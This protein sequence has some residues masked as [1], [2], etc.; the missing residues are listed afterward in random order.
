MR[1]RNRLDWVAKLALVREFQ[2]AQNLAPDDPV[3]A[4]P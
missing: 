3:A 1:C 2:A 4:K